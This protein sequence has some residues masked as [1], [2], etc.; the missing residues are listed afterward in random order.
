ME[1]EEKSNRMSRSA[2]RMIGWL[3]EKGIGVVRSRLDVRYC[4]AG[5]SACADFSFLR[6][7]SS[8]IMSLWG[9]GPD[10]DLSGCL[11]AEKRG[12]L[13]LLPPGEQRL[14]ALPYQ[15]RTAT[16]RSHACICNGDIHKRFSRNVVPDGAESHIH[17][18]LQLRDP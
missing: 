3:R 4:I 14:L 17:G 5:V 15:S 2:G 9:F 13:Y 7:L 6:C 16:S 12:R 11:Y 10:D 8:A 1:K 18:H